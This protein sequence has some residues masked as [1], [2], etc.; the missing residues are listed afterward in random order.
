MP[1]KN[2]S[3]TIVIWGAGGHALVVADVIR[4]AGGVEI[5]GFLDDVNFSRRGTQFGEATI[6]GGREQLDILRKRGI[7]SLIVA[8]GN[9]DARL[10]LAAWAL[11]KGFSLHTAIHPRAC[12]AR[13]VVLGPGTVVAAGAVIN[14]K[15]NVG[16]SVIVNTCA[17]VDHESVL[18]DGVHICPGVRTAGNVTIGRAA[19]IGIG[20]II[21]D[22]VR[23]GPRAVIGAGAVVLDD[24]PADVLAY[25]VP[26]RVKKSKG[27]DDE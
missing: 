3:R 13:D 5:A 25:G 8:V 7:A 10:R 15:V 11:D 26:A 18:E 17:S 24:I 4:S 1:T 14:P 27:S 22:G 9:C 20:A 12:L 6:L 21:G 19:W 2:P 16:A 23:I